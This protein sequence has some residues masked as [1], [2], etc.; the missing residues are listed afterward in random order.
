[1]LMASG[2]GWLR[3]RWAPGYRCVKLSHVNSFQ[4]SC[5]LLLEG[6]PASS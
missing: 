2:T 6:K 3:E 5:P 1:M 4:A